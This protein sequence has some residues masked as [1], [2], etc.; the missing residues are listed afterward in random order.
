MS[1][2]LQLCKYFCNYFANIFKIFVGGHYMGEFD[3]KAFRK[4]NG[5]NQ[6]ELAEYLG[7]GQ[8]FVSQMERGDRPI[9]KSIMEK[10]LN[11]PE[12]TIYIDTVEN[13]GEITIQA[14][15]RPAD[16][17]RI[18]LVPFEA[19]A[20]P[21]SF[22]FSD[23]VALDYYEVREFKGADFLI[24]VKGDSMSPKY[25]GGD[26]VACKVVNDVLFF[27]Y[28][29]VYV[30]YTKSQGVMIKKIEPAPDP[31]NIACVSF[32]PEYGAFDVP[33]SDIAAVALVVGSIT[34]E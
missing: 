3:L 1:I 20:G 31:D 32:N 29:R 11:N 19:V 16:T 7:I 24:R 13:N 21:G 27:Q 26:L 12:W 2:Y 8:G 9:P 5:I 30:I 34:L 4:A 28:G 23:E 25:T 14:E 33:K 6:Q 18:P 10:I 17:K 15:S 22:V